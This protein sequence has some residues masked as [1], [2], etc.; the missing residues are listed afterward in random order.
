MAIINVIFPLPGFRSHNDARKVT[1]IL[2][3]AAVSF[4][5]CIYGTTMAFPAVAKH[6]L[7]SSNCTVNA[8]GTLTEED[9]A[10]CS[11]NGT[12]EIAPLPFYINMDDLAYIGMRKLQFRLRVFM[13]T[14][15]KF[16]PG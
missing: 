1:Q 12:L 15:T 4:G 7:E 10:I 6:S 3:V 8:T 2:A 11:N 5:A 13:C 14:L 9:V 16:Y